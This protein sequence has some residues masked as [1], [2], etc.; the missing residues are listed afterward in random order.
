V[1]SDEY[2]VAVTKRGHRSALYGPFPNYDDAF[3]WCAASAAVAAYG[4]E[5]VTIFSPEPPAERQF[6]VPASWPVAIL[7]WA[8]EKV[9]EG[10]AALLIM[11]VLIVAGLAAVYGIIIGLTYAA[12]GLFGMSFGWG[13][14][15]ALG[16]GVGCGAVA[17][18]VWGWVTGEADPEESPTAEK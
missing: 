9:V 2:F 17:A 11:G 13:V 12:M 15:T 4:E 7:G 6:Y 10:L 18:G 5:N 1:E 16:V 8:R 14:V 3:A